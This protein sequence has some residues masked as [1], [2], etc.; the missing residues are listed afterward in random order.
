M[1]YAVSGGQAL[2]SGASK[3]QQSIDD[4]G[5][6]PLRVMY[7]APLPLFD[8]NRGADSS[9]QALAGLDQVEKP[10]SARGAAGWYQHARQ[11]SHLC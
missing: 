2:G 1:A 7:G 4:R 9:A 3:R 8:S 5:P 6:A 10:R 11:A